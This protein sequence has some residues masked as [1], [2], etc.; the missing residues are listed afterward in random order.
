MQSTLTHR[1]P[2]RS[3]CKACFKPAR[4]PLSITIRIWGSILMLIRE[5][6]F[7]HRF[8][9]PRAVPGRAS[10]LLPSGHPI[11][12]PIGHL[13]HDG[14]TT[15]TYVGPSAELDV[16]VEMA[17]F[18]GKPSSH[19]SRIPVTEAEEHIFGAVL[20]N[21]WS[22]Q[23][24]FS[25]LFYVYFFLCSLDVSD[26]VNFQQLETS[27]ELRISPSPPSMRRT[28]PLPSALGL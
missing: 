18:I 10:S 27:S 11:I 24:L 28:L 15:T 5:S 8:N 1:T 14:Q 16:E 26:G 21:D 22:S 20:L 9:P 6:V 7:L 13:F 4:S 23:L 17:F 3:T 12:R 2:R 25:L 19:F